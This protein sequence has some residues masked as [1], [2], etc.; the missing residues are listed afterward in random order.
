MH[1]LIGWLV[2]KPITKPNGNN[3]VPFSRR[4]AAPQSELA[5]VA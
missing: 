4:A 2:K 3:I 5:L 1:E